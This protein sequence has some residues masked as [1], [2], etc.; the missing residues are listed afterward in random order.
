MDGARDGFEFTGDRMH[1][2]SQENGTDTHWEGDQSNRAGPLR[3]TPTSGVPGASEER[4]PHEVDA[5]G[6]TALLDSEAVTRLRQ[7]ALLNLGEMNAVKVNASFDSPL[8]HGEF[9]DTFL[10]AVRSVYA[11]PMGS[12]SFD[13][14]Y[15]SWKHAGSVTVLAEGPGKGRTTTARA[16]LAEL[17]HEYPET[18]V[19]QLSFGGMPDFPVHRLPKTQNWAYVMELPSDEEDY[20][21]SE[22][23][24]AL[25]E[26][27]QSELSRRASRLV[28]L[29][30][31]DQWRRI[32]DGAPEGVRHYLG[33]PPP[34][35][36]ARKWLNAEDPGV[37]VDQWLRDDAILGL[38]NGQPPVEVL[39][40]VS[41]ILDA[42]RANDSRLPN[43]E[44]LAHKLGRGA[45][46]PFDRQ[47]L[48]VLAARSSWRNELLEWHK[49]PLR[50]SFQRNFLVSCS[51]LRGAP[52]AHLYASAA[53]LSRMLG[54][55]ELMLEGQNE[56]GVIEMVDS[57]D[58]ELQPDDTL[59]F[60]RPDWDD[61]V[62]E[63]FWVD[64]PLSRTKFLE[65]LAEAPLKGK[66][67]TLESLS[68]Q[69]QQA[70]AQRIGAFAVRWAVRQRRQDPLRLLAVRWKGKPLWPTLVELLTSASLHTASASYVHDMLLQWAK[71][72]A[73]AQRLAAVE[74]CA[75]EF[76]L[77]YTVK[78]LRRLRHAAAFEDREV[79]QALQAAVH[80]LWDDPTARPTL[81]EYVVTWCRSDAT[82]EAGLKAF[83][84]LAR[85]TDSTSPSLPVLLA[86]E[87]GSSFS[88]SPVDLTV[89]WRAVLRGMGSY[90]ED[91]EDTLAVRLW[92]DAVR[93]Y[94]DLKQT[95]LTILSEAVKEVRSNEEASF[96][97]QERESPRDRL[98]AIVR[99]WARAGHAT[100][101]FDL[102]GGPPHAPSHNTVYAELSQMLDDGL[103][104]TFQQSMAA[105]DASEPPR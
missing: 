14:L 53:D 24:G 93:S 89:G 16:L 27:L 82:L 60:N 6:L 88:P 80:T 79:R 43:L 58:A 97:D 96:P 69:E 105:S 70:L 72:G 2:G 94:P 21:V 101:S 26:S 45:A 20:R 100:A 42:H 30:T 68:T 67:D 74:V 46:T 65:W 52:V 32:G 64:R 102:F 18:H 10:T 44:S 51:S 36:I 11:R 22:T 84:T 40:I 77:Q 4:Q 3:A 47:V 9:S 62:L 12:T 83:R 25:I 35:E 29:T 71:T 99:E 19:G 66:R 13:D 92:L 33:T 86:R 61:A 49:N 103:L 28:V 7:L 34:V 54:D 73:A 75:G 90:E 56:P 95:I 38:L 78:A 17:R 39:R 1:E 98:R 59:V 91:G 37:P 57:I 15:Q 50:T 87:N 55:D 5:L 85:S 76:G 23:F 31:P 8:D 41:Y 63:Y 104:E 48:S 81:F